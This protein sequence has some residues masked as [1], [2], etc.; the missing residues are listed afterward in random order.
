MNTRA[1]ALLSAACV[2]AACSSQ[3][4]KEEPKP[5]PAPAAPAPTPVA[6][7]APAAPSKVP[8]NP[9]DDPQNILYKK[10]V[11]FDFDKYD[12]KPEYQALVQAHAKYIAANPGAKVAIQGNCDEAGS[13]EY[14]LALGQRRA[15]AVKKAM[16]LLG[17]K[18]AQLE[19]VSFGKEKPKA[20]GHDEAAHAENR[21][22]DI[23]YKVKQ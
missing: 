16:E 20:L 23:D 5:Q 8:M 10:S 21:R 7:A 1:I 15:D 18:D 2:L 11:Y 22:D 4:V 14:N 3:P 13:S 19:A 17:A 6:T 12:V 9:L